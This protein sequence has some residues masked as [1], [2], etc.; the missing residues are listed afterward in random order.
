MPDPS[1]PIERAAALLIEAYRSGKPIARRPK[2]AGPGT[3]DDAFA[4][5][6]RVVA[7][8]GHAGGWKVGA[9]GKSVV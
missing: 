8:L 6:D 3:R 4:I 9:S 7:A 2:D 5:Q 1:D